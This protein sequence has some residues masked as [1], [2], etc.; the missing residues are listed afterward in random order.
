MDHWR[1]IPVRPVRKTR[2]ERRTD[3]ASDASAG[4]EYN[5]GKDALARFTKQLL[6][7]HVLHGGYAGKER[8]DTR[9]YLA[10]A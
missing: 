4:N 7:D 2:Q 10:R 5:D 8:H 9:R 3:F 1:L 6:L